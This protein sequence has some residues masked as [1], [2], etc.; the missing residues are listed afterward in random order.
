MSYVTYKSTGGAR[1][2]FLAMLQTT[3][4][5]TDV[6]NYPSDVYSC[7]V[8]VITIDHTPS[9]N[10]QTTRL[11]VDSWHSYPNSEWTITSEVGNGSSYPYPE[12]HFVVILSRKPFFLLLNLLFP[13]MI[14]T[15]MN[16]FSFSI[17]IE[18]DQ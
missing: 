13:V 10:L 12:V 4:C 1:I 3:S 11:H 9:I 6:T 7:D 2:T 14:L 16:G 17:P 5:R 8:T 18:S 15:F